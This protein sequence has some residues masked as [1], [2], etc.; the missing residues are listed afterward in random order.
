MNRPLP[1]YLQ[2]SG[3]VFIVVLVICLGLVSLVLYFGNAMAMAYRGADNQLAGR[4]AEQ[5]VEGG[6]RYAAYLMSQLASSGS[7]PDPTSYD[8]EAV[9]VGEGT[10]WFIGSPTSSGSNTTATTSSSQTTDQP[11]F[12]LVDEASKLNLNTASQAML[13][14]LPG[15][16][17]NLSSAIVSWR[18]SS[19]DTSSSS[20]GFNLSDI[21]DKG[22]P[23]ETIAELGLLSTGSNQELLYGLDANFNHVIEP[24]ENDGGNTFT[25]G[26][27][28]G[29]FGLLE[30][31]TVFSREPNTKAD[32]TARVNVTRW[33]SELGQL[34][35]STFGQA[36]SDRIQAT[37]YRGNPVTSVLDFYVRCGSS[38]MS[39][40]DFDKISGSLT[41]SNSAFLTGLVNV[42]TASATVLACIPGIG[43]K[44]SQLVSARQGRTSPSTNL[45]WVVPILGQAGAVKA[46]PFLTIKTYQLSA[47]VAGVGRHGRG[48]R[49]TL[50]VLDSSGGTPRVVYRRNL[51]GLGWALGPS[52]RDIKDN[53]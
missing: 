36:K 31:T 8:S 14:Q 44:A 47:D 52:A 16:T 10:F 42:N 7:M 49:R 24:E 30:Y 6:A 5:A 12:G 23:F 3:S 50:F 39:E 53:Q 9:P 4:Q 32:G 46:G 45:A 11:V 38:L 28:G 51:S 33:S 17:P 20:S 25:T 21:P 34:L 41:V 2:E 19:S 27:S 40:S 18:K 48:Y 35:S 29:M 1:A 26:D 37:V 43:D 15:M 13:D 22:A